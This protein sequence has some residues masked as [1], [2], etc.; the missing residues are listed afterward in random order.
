M[1]KTDLLSAPKGSGP[2]SFLLK[3]ALSGVTYKGVSN[4]QTFQVPTNALTESTGT[5][6]VESRPLDSTCLEFIYID[7]MAVVGIRVKKP[8]IF[9][10]TSG[11]KG[12][13]S[14]SYSTYII[15]DNVPTVITQWEIEDGTAGGYMSV[16][17]TVFINA[18]S[19]DEFLTTAPS[20]S[21][22]AVNYTFISGMF[23]PA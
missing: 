4:C 1:F 9:C 22:G 13:I 23:I 21:S 15:R 5:N 18:K 19:G 17:G 6:N 7:S 20:G 8:G 10:F 11:T 2:S 14:N 16:G 3:T 12:S